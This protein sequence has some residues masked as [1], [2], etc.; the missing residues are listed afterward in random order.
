MSSNIIQQ[1]TTLLWIVIVCLACWTTVIDAQHPFK[2]AV[3]ANGKINDFGFNAMI[4]E[5]VISAQRL[6]NS[7][8]I[9]IYPDIGRG[10]LNDTIERLINDGYNGIITTSTEMTGP[11]I[12]YAGIHPE[13]RFL[14][15]G[16]NA[17]TTAN[18]S[19]FSYNIAICNYMIGYFAGL[20]TQTK[21]IGYV[22]PGLP[23][24]ANYNANALFVGAQRARP[25]E[26]VTVT[27][28]NTGSW[29]A[30]D[31]ATGATNDII[32]RGIDI[33]S[34]NQD[35]NTV[36]TAGL[37]RGVIGMGTN[38]YP[39]SRLYGE[40]I[41]F[42][43]VTNWAPVFINFTQLVITNSSY[44]RK[45]WGD[46]NN[47]FLEL[48]K[49]SFQVN[50]T[51]RQKVNEE[52]ERLIGMPFT[53]H[54]YYCNE[55]NHF[56]FPNMSATVNNCMSVAQ[57][58]F[59][60]DPYPGIN[61]L[62]Y[63]KVPLTKVGVSIP[64]LIGLTTASGVMILLAVVLMILVFIYRSSSSIRSASPFFCY[65]IIF[66]GILTYVGVIV[67]S[68][69]KSDA[70]CNLRFWFPAVGYALL[71]GS[72]VVKN[73][74]IWL[75]FDNPRLKV[76][77]VT[78]SQLYPWVMG[79][80][81]I[82]VALL[83]LMAVGPIGNLRA[84]QSNA[85]LSK[86]QFT[87]T[88]EMTR[89]GSILLILVLCVFALLIMIGSFVSWKIRIVDIL[90]FNECKPIAYVLY[91]CLVTIFI[92]VPLMVSPQTDTSQTII[93]GSAALFITTISLL[94]LFIPKFFRVYNLDSS[95]S[96]IFESMGNTK[97]SGMSGLTSMVSENPESRA[98]PSFVVGEEG[99]VTVTVTPEHV[100][101]SA[102]GT[103][104]AS[105][106]GPV[107]AT[108]DSDDEDDSNASKPPTETSA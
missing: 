64:V 16:R 84:V 1:T 2:I 20:W 18:L 40:N 75:I 51:I 11:T 38:G 81:A 39:Q 22:A 25:G 31:N 10:I 58:F 97:L 78:N 32:D 86:Y 72:L 52:V 63:Y 28:W 21:M 68:L 101:A 26:N 44:S 48:S 61:Y 19:F 77:R 42:G 47:K 92:V 9:H 37:K 13:I 62:G 15:R 91:A 90:E 94:I 5:G 35:D 85:G 89:A 7:T 60:N 27:V 43:F 70:S 24:V 50:A 14:T 96:S 82:I 33:I 41:A 99:N 104:S 17:N 45:D 67:F 76:V 46:F 88:C 105:L 100:S 83:I 98:V 87:D 79:L 34:Q 4:N 71:I 8:N 66:G 56:I 65:N 57:F 103:T 53:S 23:D 12:F 3:V 93:I 107:H 69:P 36:V 74:R 6:L 30:V 95:S 106:S 29:H 54:P 108:F 49:F 80:V 73:F 59:M 102:S 55:Y